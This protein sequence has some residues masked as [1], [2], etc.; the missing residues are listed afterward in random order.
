MS[1]DSLISALD[2]P[3]RR[4]GLNKVAEYLQMLFT[5]NLSDG[6]NMMGDGN[7]CS[8]NFEVKRRKP[9]VIHHPPH[10]LLLA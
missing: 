6:N 4:I 8:A 10:A 7:K 9:G 5:S 3:K 1:L 2:E